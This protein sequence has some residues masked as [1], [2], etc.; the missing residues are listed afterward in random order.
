MNVIN[1]VGARPNFM[2]ISPIIRAMEEIPGM[3]WLLVHTGQH[4]DVE[5]S[6]AFFQELVI[7]KPDINL[8]VGSGS[9]AHQT[10]QIMMAF[11]GVCLREKPDLVLVV[12][13][14]NSTIACSLV[15]SK[16]RIPVAHVEAGLRSF[17]RRMPEEINRM[18]TDIL[19]TYLFTTCEEANQN[20]LR[21]GVAPEKIF[22]V[23][24]VM[25]DTLYANLESIR[26][27]DTWRRLGLK[28][29][30][31]AVLTL[32]RPAN[33]DDPKVF[34]EIISGL[35]EI[36]TRL[37]IVFPIHPR[38]KRALSRFGYEGSFRF[39]DVEFPSAGG[40]NK[41]G[42]VR[43]PGIWCC[44]ALGY[45]DFQNL[46][47]H[48]KFVMTDSGGIQEETT[49][50]GIPCLTL[51]DTTER[52]VTITLGTNL[53]LGHDKRRIIEEAMKILRGEGKGGQSPPLWDGRAAERIVGIL[54]RE[55]KISARSAARTRQ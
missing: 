18:V 28:R 52:P 25:I 20:L 14:V 4:Y 38:T 7:P 8:E 9:H 12:G 27:K 23:G 51:R 48:S 53:L 15:A 33:V 22:L 34:Q 40:S 10:G 50:L 36:S 47:V 42:V 43:G 17:D 49:V 19:S 31:Y 1:V 46:V 54:A 26:K 39:L 21:E 55:F 3:G 32:H 5:M 41:N 24:D 35:D 29:K 30:E 45:L 2:K 37:P 11:E 16:L 6:E 44:D 13:D